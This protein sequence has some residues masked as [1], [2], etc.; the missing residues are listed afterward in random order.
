MPLA[1]L[2]MALLIPLELRAAGGA[3]SYWG[4]LG[5]S[6]GFLWPSLAGLCAIGAVTA[7][8]AY[9]RQRRYGLPGAAVWAAFA[10]VLGVPGWIAYRFHRTWPVLEECPACQQPSPRG[11]EAC[12]ECGGEFPLPPLKGIEVFA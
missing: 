5:M 11:R 7:A 1:G 4:A 12:T 2:T 3:D 6:L 10:F 8:L 9:R